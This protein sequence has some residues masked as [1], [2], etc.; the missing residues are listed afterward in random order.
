MKYFVETYPYLKRRLAI[1]NIKSLSYKFEYS[2]EIP[3]RILQISEHIDV[4]LSEK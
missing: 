3:N 4:I 2:L 1:P